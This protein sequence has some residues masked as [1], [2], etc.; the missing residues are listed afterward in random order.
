MNDDPAAL[1]V[2]VVV[3]NF[4]YGRFLAAA[5]ESGLSQTHP[6]T[7]VIVV[8][9]GST[10]DSREILR[11]YEDRVEVVL[12]ENGGQ[13]S[14]LNAG[15]ERCGGEIVIFLDADDVL[16]PEAAARAAAALA[17]NPAAAKAQLRM[18]V[19]DAA[20]E[21][22]GELKPPP[23]LPMP[24]GDLRHAELAYPF[25]LAW[26]PTSANAFRLE[27]LRRILP[28]PEQEF[29]VSADWHLVHLSTL[30]GEVAT[31]QEVSSSYRIHGANNYEPQ[32]AEVDLERV[33]ATIAYARATSAGLLSLADRLGL[34]RPAEI[35]S[36]A[37]L[38]QRLISLR[39]DPANH[40]IATD[41]RSGLLWDSIRAAR[42]RDNASPLL[43]LALVAW[44]AAMALA[45]WGLAERLAAWFLFPQ[46]RAGLSRLFGR[47]QRD[48][49][50]G[51]AG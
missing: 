7:H 6:A 33:R 24:S 22:T 26:L 25:D 23:R 46:S 35:L 44:F 20:G 8:D 28:I 31:V 42:R 51:C 10:D 19:I 49:A 13:A 11:R 1:H 21:P 18:D 50:A 2:D 17:A 5:I 47:L 45:P 38:G 3:D 40:P 15:A 4:N 37:D 16:H 27:P 29:R 32:T 14:A 41:T 34:P 48:P 12:K 9:D 30:L 43:R 39:L 36:L